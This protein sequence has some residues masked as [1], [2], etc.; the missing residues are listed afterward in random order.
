MLVVVDWVVGFGCED[1]IGRDEFSSLVQKLVERVLGIGCRFS[2]ENG[3]GGVVYHFPVA[4][5]CFSVGFHR[6]LL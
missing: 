6:Q 2:E 1:E 3:S 5:D 4:A